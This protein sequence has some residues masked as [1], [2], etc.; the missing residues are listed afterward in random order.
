MRSIVKA[1]AVAVAEAA[2]HF[3]PANKVLR[4]AVAALRGSLQRERVAGAQ[5]IAEFPRRI[6]KH[7]GSQESF[8]FALGIRLCPGCQ[9]PSRAEGFREALQLLSAKLYWRGRNVRR[10]LRPP[11]LWP[12]RYFALFGPRSR[13]EFTFRLDAA[14]IAWLR[15]E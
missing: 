5:G 12:S 7:L 3:D 1:K 15:S 13:L 2:V 8:E 11:Q 14:G 6:R 4:T 10:P 9:P